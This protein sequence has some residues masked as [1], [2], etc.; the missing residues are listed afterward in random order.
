ML[1]SEWLAGRPACKSNSGTDSWL[2]TLSNLHL[3]HYWYSEELL[4]LEQAGQT[5]APAHCIGCTV[6]SRHPWH[7][8][9][10]FNNSWRAIHHQVQCV[11]QLVPPLTLAMLVFHL[12]AALQ[13][14]SLSAGNGHSLLIG[15]TTTAVHCGLEN[16]L[17][18]TLRHWKRAG[19]SCTLDFLVG[20]ALPS[21]TLVGSS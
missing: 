5:R 9:Q 15:A 10:G 7:G 8:G 12:W 19:T 1:I 2:R 14:V 3:G 13:K 17:M 16:S 20:N 18:Q 6:S 11:F 21:H 4:A